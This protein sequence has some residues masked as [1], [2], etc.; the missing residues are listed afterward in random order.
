MSY[1]SADG[2]NLHILEVCSCV[3]TLA[4]ALKTFWLHY[5]FEKDSIPFDLKYFQLEMSLY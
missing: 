1:T 3:P 5:E 4:N 2:L